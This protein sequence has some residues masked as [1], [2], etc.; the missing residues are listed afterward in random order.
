MGD[1]LNSKRSHA[2]ALGAKIR[3]LTDDGNELMRI[4][5]AIARDEDAP[6]S[7]RRGAVEWLA[8]R[9]FG[10]SPIVV[11]HDVQ[12]HLPMVDMSKLS[13]AEY[14]QMEATLA[15]MLPAGVEPELA[16]VDRDFIEIQEAEC[17]CPSIDCPEHGIGG[18]A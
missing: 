15:K 12:H 9:G 4:M 11:E 17:T 3:E 8:D 2:N 6:T 16:G 18:D 7:D 1:H 13:I 10:K 14:R 5:F